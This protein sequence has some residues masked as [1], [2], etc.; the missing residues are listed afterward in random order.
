MSG[1]HS[2]HNF[3]YDIFAIIK[4]EYININNKDYNNSYYYYN[5]CISRRYR[6]EQV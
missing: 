1:I 6:K 5:G 2:S 3:A 4:I